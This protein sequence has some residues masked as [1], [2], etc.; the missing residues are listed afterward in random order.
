MLATSMTSSAMITSR[1]YK[2]KAK[3]T[4]ALLLCQLATMLQ[5]IRDTIISV[6]AAMS[7]MLNISSDCATLVANGF[8]GQYPVLSH[9]YPAESPQ[10]G[11]C[12]TQLRRALGLLLG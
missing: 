1:G 7:R 5:T 4:P 3:S 8:T 11:G 6:H 2:A 10:R 9:Q 12:G